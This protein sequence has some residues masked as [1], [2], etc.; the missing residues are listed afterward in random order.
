[1][2]ALASPEPR[3]ELPFYQA[4]IQA[5]TR[6]NEPAYMDLVSRPGVT[7][8]KA[9]LWVFLSSL[10]GW[11]LAAPLIMMLGFPG[12]SQ[13]GGERP[14]I[15]VTSLGI[16]L[17]CLI[18][19]GAGFALLAMTIFTGLNHLIA[20]GLGGAGEFSRLLYAVAAYTA[21]LA[22]L[23]PPLSVIPLASCIASL[24]GFYTIFLNILAIKA[25]YGLTWGRAI[26]SSTLMISLVLTFFICCFAILLI[27]AGAFTIPGSSG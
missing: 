16:G 23:S 13:I 18:P 21:P 26:A 2:D 20:K 19:L 4:W 17:A 25:V 6:P 15:D 5:L 7:S 1:M 11:L 27:T 12:L 9:Y 8:G 24:L 14:L 22:I 3:R 10:I